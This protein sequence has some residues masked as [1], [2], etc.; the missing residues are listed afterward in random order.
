[1][2]ERYLE[3]LMGQNGIDWLIVEGGKSSTSI[4]YLTQG[5]HI[6][7]GIFLKKRERR[8]II[9]HIDMERDNVKHLE[10]YEKVPFSALNLREV[11]AIKDPIERG[12]AYYKKIF[13]FF[14]VSGRISVQTDRFNNNVLHVYKRLTEEMK[15]IEFPPLKQDL[16]YLTRRRKTPEEI[17]KLK[18]VAQK[19]Q[20]AFWNLIEFLRGLPRKNGFLEY[21][22]RPFTIGMARQFLRTELINQGLIDGAGMIIAQGRDGGVPHNHGNDEEPIRV[23]VPIVF[24][25]YP[26]E[27]GGGFFFDMTRDIFFW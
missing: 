10:D 17:K 15:D 23:G 4:Y 22:G 12:V 21:E 25:I 19:T 18:K 13:E 14:G 3:D 7:S 1:M 5:A 27:Y 9:V 6:G 24:D 16:V 20:N 8:P 2:N 26:N 11:N